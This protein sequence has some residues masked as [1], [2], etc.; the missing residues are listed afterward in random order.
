MSLTLQ[1]SPLLIYSQSNTSVTLIF[2]RQNTEGISP[3]S[4]LLL[5]L[6][7]LPSLSHVFW[8][9]HQDLA[10]A[11]GAWPG[12]PVEV[13]KGFRGLEPP[14]S[15][16]SFETQFTKMDALLGTQTGLERLC[17]PFSGQRCF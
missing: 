3:K 5:S 1:R 9:L 4:T 15:G 17:V 13:V 14:K 7:A 8:V 10:G 2:L 6:V 11:S 16:I 12:A